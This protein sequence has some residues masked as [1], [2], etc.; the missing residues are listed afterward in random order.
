MKRSR[1]KLVVLAALLIA[2]TLGAS[3]AGAAPVAAG[4]TECSGHDGLGTAGQGA[5]CVTDL[6]VPAYAV[7]PIGPQH[8][9]DAA[10]RTAI[11]GAIGDGT[12]GDLLFFTDL[13]E[14]AAV[15]EPQPA[16]VPEPTTLAV[17][18]LGLLALGLARRRATARG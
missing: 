5:S 12:D 18:G 4:T 11:Y 8:L 16:A 3:S 10:A 1:T 14:I 17:F 15:L 7:G 2:G 9:A 13:S 6:P